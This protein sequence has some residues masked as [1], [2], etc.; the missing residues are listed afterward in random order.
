[1][2]HPAKPALSQTQLT[3]DQVWLLSTVQFKS[4]EVIYKKIMKLPKFTF[5]KMNWLS[6]YLL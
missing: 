2:A 6:W 4:Y 5:T 1:M 3:C